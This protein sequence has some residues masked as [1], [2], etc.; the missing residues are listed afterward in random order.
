MATS[1]LFQNVKQIKC[2]NCA[3]EQQVSNETQPSIKIIPVSGL[4]EK[5]E[6]KHEDEIQTA[7]ESL[8][9]TSNA[10]AIK[11]NSSTILSE[12]VKVQPQSLYRL[13]LDV[14]YTLFSNNED[15]EPNGIVSIVSVGAMNQWK[16]TVES[17]LSVKYPMICCQFFIP[18]GVQRIQVEIRN[19]FNVDIAIPYQLEI[20]TSRSSLELITS[21][22]EHSWRI[23]RPFSVVQPSLLQESNNAKLNPFSCGLFN[24]VDH[25]YVLKLPTTRTSTSQAFENWCN[26]NAVHHQN[27]YP[28]GAVDK[29]STKEPLDSTNCAHCYFLSSKEE[30]IKKDVHYTAAMHE[31]LILALQNA[32]ECNRERICVLSDN[33]KPHLQWHSKIESAVESLLGKRNKLDRNWSVLLF[34]SIKLTQSSSS[35]SS[36]SDEQQW[37]KLDDHHVQTEF[38]FAVQGKTNMQKLLHYLLE[39]KQQLFEPF[40]GFNLLLLE[41]GQCYVAS[42]N[43]FILLP[44]ENPRFETL[45][46]MFGGTNSFECIDS[47]KY[48]TFKRPTVLMEAKTRT[49]HVVVGLMDYPFNTL[50]TNSLVLLSTV[51]Q[52]VERLLRE[53][54]QQTYSK[55]KIHV[56]LPLELNLNEDKNAFKMNSLLD[57]HYANYRDGTLRKS[58][59]K[60]VISKSFEQDWIAWMNLMEHSHSERFEMEIQ[61][62][63]ND[64]RFQHTPTQT[65]QATNA[66]NFHLDDD[67]KQAKPQNQVI[68]HLHAN[69]STNQNCKPASPNSSHFFT[70]IGTFTSNSLLSFEKEEGNTFADCSQILSQ[71]AKQHCKYYTLPRIL[72][73]SQ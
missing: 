40:L 50:N 68:N 61:A 49:V 29:T 56:F 65:V 69:R 62:W 17:K 71:R 4:N 41:L 70:T 19:H 25:V 37:M 47:N 31:M 30:E 9:G 34:G 44:A 13:I 6:L 66:T 3:L 33:V 10:T 27:I 52:N 60:E 57:I 16:Y 5:S 8:L 36:F 38:S 23:A 14:K 35:S 11:S 24:L 21:E 59:L 67:I 2:V 53:M 18:Q 64:F 26:Q 51:W 55:W 46:K 32:L 7:I 15:L 72:S 48:Q 1:V 43:V 58:I 45:S 63:S 42:P 39:A 54:H 73:S 20:F 12:P 22:L 28:E